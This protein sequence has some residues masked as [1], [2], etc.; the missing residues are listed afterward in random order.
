LESLE[1]GYSIAELELRNELERID[2]SGAG[3]ADKTRLFTRIAHAPAFHLDELPNLRRRVR[4]HRIS[5]Q[6]CHDHLVRLAFLRWRW[7]VRG[8]R[9]RQSTPVIT[10]IVW[11][12]FNFMQGKELAGQSVPWALRAFASGYFETELLER[13]GALAGMPERFATFSQRF[14]STAAQNLWQ[15]WVPVVTVRPASCAALLDGLTRL[16]STIN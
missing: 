8:S 7:C 12:L 5:A 3:S 4:E 16:R 10:C 9:Q 1:P 14:A 13:F 15:H 2:Q 11:W 6:G